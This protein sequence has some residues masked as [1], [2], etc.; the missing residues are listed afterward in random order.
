MRAVLA[1]AWRLLLSLL[2]CAGGGGLQHTQHQAIPLPSGDAEER[3][4]GGLLTGAA[5]TLPHLLLA[6][7]V[8]GFLAPL[9][10]ANPQLRGRRS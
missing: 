8:A 6:G 10:L 7:P 9:L 2:S 4:A 1:C 3:R 5:H